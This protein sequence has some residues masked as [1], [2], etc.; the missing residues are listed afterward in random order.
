MQLSKDLARMIKKGSTYSL[1]MCVSLIGTN[2]GAV[3][4]K[5]EPVITDYIVNGNFEDKEN[6]WNDWQVGTDSSDHISYWLFNYSEDSYIEA[7]EGVQCIKYYIDCEETI[8]H[9]LTL[10]QQVKALPAGSYSLFAHV[11][12]DESEVHLEV[13][14]IDSSAHTL[15]GWNV[16]DESEVTFDL[17]EETDITVRL[18]ISGAAGAW[19]YIDDITLVPEG[20]VEDAPSELP[21]DEEEDEDFEVQQADIFV[22]RVEGI[23]DDFIRGM[24]V[25][26]LI[27]LEESGVTFYNSDGEAQDLL[28]ILSESGTNYIRVR[29]WHNPYDELGQGYGGGNC[30]LETAIAIGQRATQYGMKVLVDF[31]YSDF[32]C[33]PAKQKV[34]K[35]WADYTVEEKQEALYAYTKESVQALLDAGVDIG[36]IQVGNET[37]N[38]F[39][40]EKDWTDMCT[41]FNAGS[42]AIRELDE[43]ILIALHFTNPETSGRYA[44]IAKKLADNGVDYDVFASSYYPYWHGTLDNLTHV[45]KDVADTYN[46]K[47]MV[48]E[49]SYAYTSEDS[50]GHENSVPK[51]NAGQTLNYDISVQRQADA[52][53][54]VAEAVV[55]IDDAGIGMFYWEPAWIAVPGETLEE[56]QEKWETYGSGWASSSSKQYD[57]E[58][59]GKWYGGSAWDSQALFD[60]NGM[61]LASSKIYSY[62]KTGAEGKLE[63]S[64]YDDVAI[65]IEQG[66]TINFP[67]KINGY[68]NNNDTATFEVEWD[69]MQIEA[70]VESG[71]GIYEITGT[72]SNG[73]KV[74]A[75]LKINPVNCVINQSFEAADCSMWH[76]QYLGE[77]AD[78]VGYQKKTADAKTGDYSVHF[79][80]DSEIDFTIEQ[81]VTDL[82]PGDYTLS[83]ALQGGDCKNSEMSLYIIVD[84]ETFE[85]PTSVN[86]WANWQVPELTDIRIEN[87]EATIGAHIKCDADG[88]GTIDDFKLYCTKVLQPEDQPQ[89]PPQEKPDKPEAD[90]PEHKPNEPSKPEEPEDKPEV[91]RPEDKPSAPS[92]PEAD[93]PN[94]KPSIPSVGGHASHKPHQSNGGGNVIK[95]EVLPEHHKPLLPP[96]V[97]KMFRSGVMPSTLHSAVRNAQVTQVVNKINTSKQAYKKN[98]K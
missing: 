42:Q 14:G 41:L 31:H 71:I 13:E 61:P 17:E 58:D 33:D 32:W 20:V 59:A 54:D 34:P 45:L 70:A 24:D 74:T 28:K 18:T 82:K 29:V 98:A 57:P 21:D 65:S 51:E 93:K 83:M 60:P 48:A 38:A 97:H 47:V 49:T 15:S 52:I 66:E 5:A 85:V 30:D 6:I 27:A 96:M 25:S 86:G 8:S 64:R 11:M 26:S 43:D 16:W 53:R 44:S 72:V 10:T 63:L 7:Q 40:G 79:W 67:K 2:F 75:V 37:I 1:A 35:A 12:G 22:D 39:C 50:D 95:P 76:I 46:K 73:D 77:T 68:Y 4:T 89:E 78:Y 36:M 23:S 84:G 69:E 3:M 88:W 9:D 87:G 91:E 56:R 62:L 19:G 80:N 81:H 90:R 55:N 92:K 94:N